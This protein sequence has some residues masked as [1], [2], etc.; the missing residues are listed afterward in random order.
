MMSRYHDS[1]LA[2]INKVPPKVL[3][4]QSS[5]ED[6]IFARGDYMKLE[7]SFLR[8]NVLGGPILHTR[9]DFFV[10]SHKSFGSKPYTVPP[11]QIRTPPWT[12]LCS[13]MSAVRINALRCTRLR[14]VTHYFV[15]I[16]ARAGVAV[17]QLC[18]GA[19]DLCRPK[20]SITG[21]FYAIGSIK[22][23]ILLNSS[24]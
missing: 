4:I 6:D 18:K 11:S 16:M 8:I 14:T 20:Q 17:K 24:Q 15:K 22:L 2:H 3:V 19:I 13:N 12:R 23:N 1:L 9:D 10:D 21:I 5:L 7:D